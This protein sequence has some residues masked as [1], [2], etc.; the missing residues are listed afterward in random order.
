MAYS[1]VTQ[2]R[3]DP[4]RQRGHAL[5]GRRGAQHPGA[6]ELHEHRP[7][8]VVEPVPGDR[9][10]AELVVGA[11]V[12][13]GLMAQTWGRPGREAGRALPRGGPTRGLER[14]GYFTS[15]RI[16]PDRPTTN[17]STIQISG[18]RRE[19]GPLLPGEVAARSR[20]R[21][22]ARCRGRPTARRR[23]APAQSGRR[24]RTRSAARSKS[25]SRPAVLSKIRPKASPCRTPLTCS[26]P[27]FAKSSTPRLPSRPRRRRPAWPASR[28]ARRTTIA[29][30][31]EDQRGDHL[32]GDHLA[33]CGSRVNVTIAVR[34]PHSLGD[35]QDAEHR[36]Q[37][38]LGVAVMPM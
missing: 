12:G 4:L 24:S 3:P 28:P 11:A 32:G 9:D 13:A 31:P 19:L 14:F 6:A 23:P 36:E 5:G 38:A 37:E 20:T 8:G 27:N 33:R 21:A 17:G 29:T 1:A 15:A 7:G 35:Q 26:S 2:P 25:R 18:R 22:A 10:R 34:W 16:T 30:R